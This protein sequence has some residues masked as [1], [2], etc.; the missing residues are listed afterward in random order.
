MKY[1][2]VTLVSLGCAKNLTDSEVM[3]SKLSK[4]GYEITNVDSEAEIAIVN[5]CCFIDSAKQESIDAILDVAKNKIDGKLKLLI[6]AGCM[7]ERFKDEVLSELP[8]VDGVCGTGDFADICSIIEKCEQERGVYASGCLNAPLDED[9]RIL[10]TPSYTAYL[11]IAE[12]CSNHCTYCVIP[13]VRGKYRSRPPEGIITE[14]EKLAKNG[15]KEL[16]LIAQDTSCYGKDLGEEITLVT[17]LRRL[18]EIEGL[19]WIRV[20]YLYPEEITDELID[21]FAENSK[22]VNYFDIPIQ[23]INNRILKL[24]ARRTDKGSIETL[25]EKIKSKMPDAV[26]RTSLIVGFPTETEQEFYELVSFL[27]EHKLQRVGAFP[28]SR[29]DG[30][31]AALMSGQ[32]DDDIKN[33]RCEKISDLQY[34][35]MSEYATSKIGTVQTVLVEGFDRMIKMYFGRT[36]GES[37]D[38]DPKVFIKSETN[39]KQG[40]F[41]DV[42]ITDA[43]DGDLIGEYKEEL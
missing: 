24:M 10:A 40:S 42:L 35:I 20:H 14:A 32:V 11:K 9:E 27:K 7:G 21:E 6:V 36:Y 1:K 5:T 8:E 13:S 38:V 19:K 39:I 31:K 25:I 17:L 16:I 34:E 22:I 2:K 4:A 37:V 15:V 33:L 23:H 3:L 18:S 43:V 26:F 28:Y 29:E 12:G 41:I 30:T